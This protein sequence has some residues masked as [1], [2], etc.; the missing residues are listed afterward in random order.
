MTTIRDAAASAFNRLPTSTRRTLLHRTGRYAPWDEGFDF[1][2]PAPGPG[3]EAGPPDFVGI[4]AQ[5]AGTTWWYGLVVAHPGVWSR[6]DVHKERHFLSRF[7]ATSFGPEEA[8]AYHGWF[9]RRRG[10]IAGEWTPEYL[11]CP[12]VPG[13]LDE[14]APGAR[15]LLILRDP[16]ERFCSGVAHERRE[17]GARGAATTAEALSR[18]FYHQAMS[19]WWRHFDDSR[20]LVLQYERCA[21]DPE[22]Q[23]AQTYRFLGLDDSFVP[24]AIRRPVSVTR[25]GKPTLSDDVRRRLVEMYLPDVMALSERLPQLDLSLWSNFA[26]A[27]R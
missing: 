8:K 27:S 19:H 12:W 11:Y 10:T 9:P 23:L 13:L 26:K 20:L 3:E 4:G 22:G 6:P 1:A 7:G 21:A 15:L 2:P 17:A 5:K 14:A 25:K 24:P 18:G 16:V